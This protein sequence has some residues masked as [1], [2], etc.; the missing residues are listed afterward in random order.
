MPTAAPRPC[1]HPGCG[2]LVR[3]GSGRCAK[4]PREAR[5][6]W[7]GDKKRGNR[8]ERGYG[9]DWT[10]LRNVIMR[11]DSYL[12]QVCLAVGRV[13]P[14][15]AVDHIVPKANNGT[16]D[17]SNLQSI[18]K[19]CH[20]TKTAVESAIMGGS[21][22]SEPQWLKLPTIPVIAVCGPPGSGKTSYVS[23]HSSSRDLVL[24][25]DVI[26]SDLFKLPMYHASYNQ[27]LMAM[28]YRNSMLAS[29]AAPNVG[30][31]KCW[32]IVTAGTPAKRVF[33]R[34]RYG[35]TLVVMPTPKTECIERIKEDARR[36]GCDLTRSI[37]A[38]WQWN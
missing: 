22:A 1:G 31:S 20:A 35:A 19:P 8:Y 14:A 25:L 7:F 4:H 24:D 3:D 17:P 33:W 38:I 2:V 28:R 23:A 16:D 36:A 21:V 27:V 29:L 37:D 11:R 5:P 15:H 32:L 26:A 12:C 10:K 18:C 9:N 13:T 6:G 34:D 30:Y